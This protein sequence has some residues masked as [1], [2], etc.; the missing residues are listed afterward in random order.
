MPQLIRTSCF[1]FYFT[2]YLI[3]ETWHFFFICHKKNTRRKEHIGIKV[4]NKKNSSMSDARATCFLSCSSA[5]IEATNVVNDHF[6][7]SATFT[8]F[9][10]N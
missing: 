7:K 6:P 9:H 1:S 10:V 4:K 8:K 2:W 3:R 5:G